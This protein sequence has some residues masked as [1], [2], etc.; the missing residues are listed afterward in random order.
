MKQPPRPAPIKIVC[1]TDIK[2]GPAGFH[3]GLPMITLPDEFEGLVR[4]TI[5]CMPEV[6]EREVENGR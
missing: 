5:E 4:V 1:H 2:Y 6:A 3:V